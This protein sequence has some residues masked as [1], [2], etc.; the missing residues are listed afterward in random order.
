MTFLER[1]RTTEKR[2]KKK[3]TKKK[4]K[5]KASINALK[6][7]Y[8]P[9]HKTDTHSWS[10]CNSNPKN[11]GKFNNGKFNNRNRRINEKFKRRDYNK[12]WRNK[13]PK[14]P[15][16]PGEN[17]EAYGHTP[18]TCWGLHPEQRPKGRK[19]A[20]IF[21]MQRE[22]NRVQEQLNNAIEKWVSS[23]G[24]ESPIESEISE[25]EPETNKEN[26]IDGTNSEEDDDEI[27]AETDGKECES[28]TESSS[29]SPISFKYRHPR[30][31]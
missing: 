6:K 9:K 8:C 7:Q 24:E 16:K 11:R 17:C 27:E 12:S 15:H 25:S 10:E 3:K 28:S 5:R 26:S 31:E 22:M 14:E 13:K 21:A 19:Q 20:K 23:E 1:A 2:A 4:A 30:H 29:E 18:A